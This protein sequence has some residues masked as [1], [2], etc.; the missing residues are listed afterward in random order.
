MTE[1]PV[2]QTNLSLVLTGTIV[3]SAATT[4]QTNPGERL[5]QYLEAVQFYQQY[6]PVIFLENSNYPLEKH[7]EFAESDRLRVRRFPPSKSSERGKGY[8]EFEMLDAWLT[9]EPQTPERWLKITGRYRVLNIG[10]VLHECQ[11]SAPRLLI[12]QARRGRV[13]RT[14][15]FCTE[16]AFYRQH[17]AGLYLQCDDRTGEWIERVL[18]RKLKDVPTKE[19]SLFKTQPRIAAVAGSGGV[20]PTGRGQRFLKQI[21][22]SVNRAFDKRYLWY[23]K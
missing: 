12:D 4:A 18:F 13:A 14:Y 9:S 15:L 22:R 8:Q 5:A 10:R 6:A 19:F 1:A 17:M 3:P 11:R 16:T 23:A 20:F 7:P 21:L 2:E